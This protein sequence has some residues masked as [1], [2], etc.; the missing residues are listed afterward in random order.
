MA[1][2]HPLLFIGF[3]IAVL[4]PASSP[5]Q[6]GANKKDILVALD[7][8]TFDNNRFERLAGFARTLGVSDS[9]IV[10]SRFN[11]AFYTG[12]LEAIKKML[13][14]FEKA[15]ETI[16]AEEADPKA[17]DLRKMLPQFKKV[18]ETGDQAR[19]RTVLEKYQRD[20]EARA[21]L[22]DLRRID[23]AIDI[24]AIES[25]LK[26]GTIIP[27]KVWLKQVKPGCRLHESGSDVFGVAYGNQTVDQM[28]KP[29]PASLERVSKFVPPDFFDLKSPS[30]KN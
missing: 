29:N 16:P 25:N 30:N 19:V 8:T 4:A 5:G 3:G 7:E 2:R 15:L 1:L 28:P 14:E 13:P 22:A 9:R 23:A 6:A 11:R 17:G 20:A 10:F 21:I 24:C 18:L 27:P 26:A 12:D